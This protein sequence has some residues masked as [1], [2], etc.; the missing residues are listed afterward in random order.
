MRSLAER[1][2]Y[3]DRKCQQHLNCVRLSHLIA[4]GA[5]ENADWTPDGSLERL[6]DSSFDKAQ[7]EVR[8]AKLRHGLH[9]IHLVALKAN[10]ELYLN[11][12]LSAIWT[13]SFLAL[14]PKMPAGRDVSLRELAESL[15]DDG[16]G[17]MKARDL[18]IDRIVPVH[19][20]RQ[21][22]TML[23]ESTGIRLPD[24]LYRTNLRYWPQIHVAFEIRHLVEHRDGTVDPTFRK[25]VAQ[26]WDTSSWGHREQLD[27]LRKIRV[28]GE[29]V[30]ATYE[31][32]AHGAALLTQELLGRYVPTMPQSPSQIVDSTGAEGSRST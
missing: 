3:Y 31:A 9:E 29:D 20:L 26:L 10:F 2:T 16:E 19:G 8:D 28:E 1:L 32:M 7:R 15:L 12:V 6:L 27:G 30:N 24:L 11:R 25:S 13:V 4:T 22:V 23:K 21:L 17:E 18:I 14:T 5:L